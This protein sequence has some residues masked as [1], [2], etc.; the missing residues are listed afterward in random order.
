MATTTTQPSSGGQQNAG[1]LS[2]AVQQGFMN[3]GAYGAI[4]QGVGGIASK[5]PTPRADLNSTNQAMAAARDGISNALLASGNPYAMAAGAAVKIIDKTGGFSD[6]SKGLGTGEDV[7]NIAMSFLLPGAGWFIKPTDKYKI[8]AEMQAM[9]GGYASAMKNNATAAGNSGAKLFFGADKANSNTRVA[10]AKDALISNIKRNSDADYET[11]ATMTQQKAMENQFENMGGY[12]QALARAGKFGMKIERAKKL[13]HFVPKPVEVIEAMRY[14]GTFNFKD[15]EE[16][17]IPNADETSTKFFDSLNF[18]EVQ[19]FQEGGKVEEKKPKFEDWVK[20]INPEYLS[21]NYDLK[22]AFESLPFE[23]LDRWKTA[24]NSANPGYFRDFKD[25]DGNYPFHLNSVVSTKDG[26]FVFLKKGKPETNPEV[27]DEL[28][29]YESGKNGLKETHDLV[30]N[31]DENRYYYIKKA[32][33]K[34]NEEKAIQDSQQNVPE[35]S[36]E[37][38]EFKEGGQMNVIP[39][40]SL[41]ARLHHMENGDKLT[42]KGIPVVDNE[43]N[44][45]AEIEKNEIIFNLEVTKKLEELEKKFREA[46][47]KR[48]KDDIAI[49][50]GKLIAKEIMENTDDRTGLINSVE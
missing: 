40:G 45:Q 42:K 10:K 32:Q 44:Q 13:G 43:G 25:K 49:E 8:S 4:A 39:D 37:V 38:E 6:G 50:A 20:D 17:I 12:S 11:M 34:E 15:P 36:G 27:Q 7:G 5:F 31:E 33:T 9:Q 35:N 26:N 48:D 16:L 47:K 23:E 29:T 21:E 19:T 24:V 1:G 30:W 18:D 2:S 14:G 46:E 28:D 41:H 3:G 22:L